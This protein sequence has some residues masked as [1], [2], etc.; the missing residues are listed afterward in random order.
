MLHFACPVL[1][2]T[3]HFQALPLLDAVSKAFRGNEG[4]VL[5]HTAT[6]LHGLFN[7]KKKHKRVESLPVPLLER[8]LQK[9][10][11]GTKWS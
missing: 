4:L 2:Y 6:H 10:G 1:G 9:Q 7:E 5:S 11:D 8:G 3:L